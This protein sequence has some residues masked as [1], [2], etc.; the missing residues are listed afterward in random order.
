MAQDQAR[1][2]CSRRSVGSKA[3]RFVDMIAPSSR[4]HDGWLDI[5][6][7]IVSQ[8]RPKGR[9]RKS[10]LRFTDRPVCLPASFGQDIR[11]AIYRDPEDMPI[12][13]N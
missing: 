8:D 7:V 6:S 1:W 2:R 5:S 11:C 13:R 3:W 9:V 4:C 12:I 10:C